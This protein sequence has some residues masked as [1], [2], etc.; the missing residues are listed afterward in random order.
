MGGCHPGGRFSK[1]PAKTCSD[2][3][4][5]I[6]TGGRGPDAPNEVCGGC[7]S[8]GF[9][10]KIGQKHVVTQ[11]LL[12]PRVARGRMP[13]T[14]YVPPKSKTIMALA[15]A[16]GRGRGRLANPL[17]RLP[18][19]LEIRIVVRNDTRFGPLNRA[20]P[21][22]CLVASIARC[23]RRI[24]MLARAP[25]VRTVPDRADFVGFSPSRRIRMSLSRVIA[26]RSPERWRR[27]AVRRLSRTMRPTWGL[28]RKTRERC[29]APREEASV[30]RPMPQKHVVTKPL[31]SPRAAGDP[32]PRRPLGARVHPSERR[33]KNRPERRAFSARRPGR[34]QAGGC[35]KNMQ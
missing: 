26:R 17:I 33:L 25:Y 6:P 20:R 24:R 27:K 4:P 29:A 11:H 19:P 31:S 16:A 28:V 32:A 5:L 21:P 2:A 18:F 14:R 8:V 35:R 9:F 3:A 12:S 30:A 13:L 15:L 22:R 7:I 34:A 23:P 10:R 1:N